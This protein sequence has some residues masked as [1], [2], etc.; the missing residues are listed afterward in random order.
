VKDSAAMREVAA[1]RT[2]LADELLRCRVLVAF[3]TSYYL[4]AV[5][6]GFLTGQSNTAL[7]SIVTAALISLFSWIHL[8]YGLSDGLLWALAVLG[9]LHLAGGLI[10]TGQ[11]QILYNARFAIHPLQLD[12]LVHAYGTAVLTLIAWQ[13]VRRDTDALPVGAA[14]AVTALA[15]LGAAAL[16]EIA[17]F[18]TSSIAP[19]HVGGYANTGW[20]LVFDLMGCVVIALWLYRRA[21]A[22]Q[23]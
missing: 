10:P 2:R 7:Y 8:R 4:I 14:V 12:R 19:T 5:F 11:D 6:A 15:A 23:A 1:T 20:D 9:A 16:E 13:V 18:T 3:V 22:G 17:E 21:E